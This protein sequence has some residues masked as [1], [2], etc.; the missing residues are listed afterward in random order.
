MIISSKPHPPAKGSTWE[1]HV[2]GATLGSNPSE[3]GSAAI[4]V[5]VNGL[6]YHAETF[7]QINTTNNR[8]EFVAL[9]HALKWAHN[10]FMKEVTVYTDSDIVAKWARGEA[11]IKD[12]DLLRIIA[13]ITH[14]KHFLSFSVIWVP[15]SQEKQAFTDYVSKLGLTHEMSFKTRKDH[16]LL[17][18]A[19][20]ETN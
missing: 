13:G 1:F 6:L 20:Y 9:F 4:T 8:I 5:W 7:Q 11:N 14:Y 2:D 10:H 15:R 3:I 17:I 19:Y 16:K 12:D 18:G